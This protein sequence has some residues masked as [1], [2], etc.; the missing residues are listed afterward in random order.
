MA[1]LDDGSTYGYH[2]KVNRWIIVKDDGST[3]DVDVDVE[4]DLAS[5]VSDNPWK[6]THIRSKNVLFSFQIPQSGGPFYRKFLRSSCG[7]IT[8]DQLSTRLSFF[9]LKFILNLSQ[10][11]DYSWKLWFSERSC[12]FEKYSIVTVCMIVVIATAVVSNFYIPKRTKIREKHFLASNWEFIFEK[13]EKRRIFWI[14]NGAEY[15]T[16]W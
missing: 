16:L 15:W 3:Y 13:W 5:C 14:G 6:K 10:K 1:N 9:L 7:H 4:K 12:H 8:N 2:N 11:N